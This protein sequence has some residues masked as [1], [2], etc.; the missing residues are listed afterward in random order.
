MTKR[1]VDFL[2]VVEID[3]Q[4]RQAALNGFGIR[5][6]GKERIQEVEELAPISKAGQVIGDR[7]AVSL[8]GQESKAP[9]RQRQPDANDQQRRCGK[10]DGDRSDLVERID[11]ENDQ[12]RAR[13]EAGEQKPWGAVA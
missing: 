1:I 11:E 2:E 5:V 6:V 4:K 7:L 9:N 12:A 10:S 3:V 8:L 13:P